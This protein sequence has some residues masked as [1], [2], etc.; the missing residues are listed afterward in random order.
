MEIERKFL[1][2]GDYKPYV[3]KSTR[4]IQ[5]YL[6]SVPERIVRIRMMGEQ[7]FLTIKGIGSKSGV[8]RFEWEIEIKKED[9]A[10][11]LEICEPGIIDK[12]R[13]IIPVKGHFFEVDEF[14]GDNEGLILAEIELS[15]ED[16]SFEKPNWLGD[17]VT[18]NLKYYNAMLKQNPYKNW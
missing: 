12:T 13:Q 16:E 11:L 10:N 18:G 2:R 14:H 9:V 4:I 3:T 8:S 5:A 7:G 17:E 6:S 1:V 15:D